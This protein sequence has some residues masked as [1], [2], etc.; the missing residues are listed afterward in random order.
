MK[1]LALNGSPNKTNG[2]THLTLQPFLDGAA[3]AG[4]EIE[5]VY[6]HDLNVEPCRGCFGCWSE[7]DECVIRDDMDELR[8][9]MGA[10]DV[11]ALAA[12]LY[13]DHI[14]G[15]TKTVLDRSIP[16]VQP[17]IELRDGHCRH[18]WKEAVS[19]LKSIVLVS[20]CGFW[21]LD[22]FHILVDWANAWGRNMGVSLAGALLRPHAYSYKY[23]PDEVPAKQAVTDAL[24]R[25]GRELVEKGRISPETENAIAAPLVSLE[26]YLEHVNARLSAQD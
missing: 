4:A 15:P 20:V 16:L 23:M 17:A 25:A 3:E 21:E 19:G 24:A 6:V 2:N 22:N 18:P 14:P 11:L 9:K 8:P 10:C 5:T 1:I 12:P 7:K 26:Q 13:V